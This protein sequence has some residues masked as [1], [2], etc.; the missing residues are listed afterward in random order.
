MVWP[1]ISIRDHRMDSREI[2]YECHFQWSIHE[3]VRAP[4]ALEFAVAGY[5]PGSVVPVDNQ[6]RTYWWCSPPRIGRQRIGPARSTARENGASFSKERCV[7]VL[8]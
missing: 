8:L 5:D 7:R 3:S 2:K 4:E 6:I 1:R